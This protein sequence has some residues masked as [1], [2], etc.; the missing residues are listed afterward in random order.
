MDS[1]DSILP[2]FH[3]TESGLDSVPSESFSALGIK[4]RSHLQRVLRSKLDVIAPDCLLIAEEFGGWDQASRRIDLLA[5]DKNANLVVIE[6]KRTEDAG[7]AELQA[8]RYAAMVSTMTFDQAVDAHRRYLAALGSTE[9]ARERILAFL[10]WATPQVDKFPKDVR[11][12]LV[13][14]NFSKELTTAVLWLRDRKIDITCV[15]LRP[16]D[17]EGKTLLDV[18]TVIPLPETA[19]YQVKVRQR[20]EIRREAAASS[21]RNQK[22]DVVAGEVVERGLYKRQALHRLV[23]ALTERGVSPEE[24]MDAVPSYNTYLFVSV[25]GDVR[26]GE[27]IEAAR[28][29]CVRQGRAFH[30]SRFTLRDDELIRFGDRTYAVTN[31]VGANLET[32]LS[33][34]SEA[35]PLPDVRWQ[36]T[37]AE[38]TV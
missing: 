19:E 27:F 34:L 3:L 8:I 33:Q 21:E 14:A 30:P 28:E 13:S 12:V 24:M 20:E 17:F 38:T 11:I 4:E 5:I 10:Q 31:Q 22:Y 9:D 6:L 36:R 7:H 23:R 32:I 18:Q 25:A 15:R 1:E 35:F 29:E 26:G 2:L 16:Y 37:E